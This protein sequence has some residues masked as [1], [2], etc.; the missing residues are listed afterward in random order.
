[1]SSSSSSV[2]TS[3]FTSCNNLAKFYQQFNTHSQLLIGPLGGKRFIWKFQ[4]EGVPVTVRCFCTVSTLGQGKLWIDKDN[5]E[6]Y[7]S[8]LFRDK[9]SITPENSTLHVMGFWKNTPE[10]IKIPKP[11]KPQQ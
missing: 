5:K 2:E 11:D 6:F 4:E 3:S 8:R 7:S 9:Y 1:M 10:E